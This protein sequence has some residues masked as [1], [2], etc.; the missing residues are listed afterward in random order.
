MTISR[1]DLDGLGSPLA[2]A[3]GIHKLVADLPTA[4]PVEELC[5][6][7]D[8]LSV[9]EFNTEGFEA[10][11]V[12]DANKAAGSILVAAGRTRKRRRY[13]VA[14]ELGHFPIPTHMPDAGHGFECSSMICTCLTPKSRTGGGVS[15]RRPTGSRP[16]C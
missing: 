1:L 11:L 16:H 10:A 3:A 13:S 12:M 5:G 2:I 9:T 7:L 6:Q 8:I 4:V 15:K 14:H